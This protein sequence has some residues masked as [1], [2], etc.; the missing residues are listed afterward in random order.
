MA[1]TVEIGSEKAQD[2]KRQNIADRRM[3]RRAVVSGALGS[4]L[5]WFDFA[6]YGALSATLFPILFFSDLGPAGAL[7]ASFATFGVG[8]LARPLGAVVC[9]YL[10]DK[11]GRRPVLLGTFIAMGISSVFIGLLPTGQGVFIAFVLVALRFVQGFSL[12]GEATGAQ[13]MTMEHA[14]GD[15]RGILGAC[16]NIGSPL[17]QVIANLTLTVLALVLSVEDFQSWGWRIPFLLSVLLV[18][19][20]V[21]IR[22]KLEETPAFVVQKEIVGE[23]KVNGLKIVKTQPL[24]ILTLILAWAGSAMTFYVVAIYGLSYMTA[25]AGFEQGESFLILVIGNAISVGAGLFGG[26]ISDRIGRKPVL[27]IGL[28]AQFVALA[29]FFPAANTGSFT[30][31]MLTVTVALS[32]VQFAFGA[33]PAL[34]AEQFP[35]A[36]RFSGSALALTISGLIFAAPAPMVAAALAGAGWY[37][38]IGVINMAVVVMSVIAMTWVKENRHVDL[39]TYV[40]RK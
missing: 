26:W 13:L 30:L 18:A 35:T 27:Y 15:R 40:I 1:V 12:G 7:I 6:I 34:F 9:G 19:V 23:K 16:I 20:G 3:S 36:G 39:A 11:F 37:W 31:A 32:G 28:A 8:F 24:T 14:K 21:Y 22:L 5:E 2:L 29:F 17:S 25:Q 10:G 33:Q 4:A 38:G